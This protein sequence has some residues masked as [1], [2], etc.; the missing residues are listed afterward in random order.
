VREVR[1]SIDALD[2]LDR[3]IAYIAQENPQAA[4]AV[5]EKIETAGNRLGGLATGR[6]G[7][8]AGVYEKVVT[9]L[10]Y[11]LAYAIEPRPDGSERIVV[12]RVIHGARN[13]L[14][15]EWPEE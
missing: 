6:P 11:I 5:I 7:R 14:E 9:G 2:D 8:M 10:A 4:R 15:D 13:W 12:L 1:W 3:I